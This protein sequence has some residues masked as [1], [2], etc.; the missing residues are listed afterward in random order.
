MTREVV[1]TRR[2]QT[3]I[4][5]SIRK[6]LGIEEGTRLMVDAEG[7]RVVLRKI[8]SVFDL[9]GTSKLTREQAVSLLDK[10]RASEG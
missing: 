4:P 5:M 1:V 6:K 10:M 3:T 7:D 2:G 8:P 9:A